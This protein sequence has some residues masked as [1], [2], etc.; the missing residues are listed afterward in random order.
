MWHYQFGGTKAA[1]AIVLLVLAQVRD[2]ALEQEVV[3]KNKEGD[4]VMRAEDPKET[5]DQ[6]L[7]KEDTPLEEKNVKL[8][9]R[10]LW[11]AT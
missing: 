6:K 2:N 1:L 3:P 9:L 7:P 4:Q 5:K 11:F 8:A 10:N